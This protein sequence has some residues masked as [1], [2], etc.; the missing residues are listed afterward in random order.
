MPRAHTGRGLAILATLLGLVGCGGGDSDDR[1]AVRAYIEQANAIQL[2]GSDGLDAANAA[3]VAYSR[4]ELGAATA[5]QR[6]TTAGD[7]LRAVRADLAALE[8]P[9]PARDLRAKLLGVFDADVALATEAEQLAAY[10]PAAGRAMAPLDSAST[11]LRAALADAP[12]PEAQGEALERY[13]AVLERL[14]EAMRE[15]EPPPVLLDSHRTQMLRLRTARRLSGRL[16]AAIAAADAVRI[17]SLLRRFAAVNAT[18]AQ[19]LVLQR[20]SVRAYRQRVRAVSLA[21]G[22]ARRAQARLEQRLG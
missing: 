2:D 13:S 20:A 4:G 10:T 15:L 3:Y 9:A 7:D 11:R 21:I 19:D 14:E 16:R 12:D 17:S 18:S 22:D 6:L 5:V 1:K 8:A